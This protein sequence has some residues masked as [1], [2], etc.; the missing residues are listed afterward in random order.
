MDRTDLNVKCT[1]IFFVCS[2]VLFMSLLK[3]VGHSGFR[4]KDLCG[5]A[6]QCNKSRAAF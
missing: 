5:V 4:N 1:S 3:S 6:G 2:G